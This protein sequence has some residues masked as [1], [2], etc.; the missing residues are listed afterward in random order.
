MGGNFSKTEDIIW[1]KKK[2]QPALRFRTV[3][4]AGPKA[5]KAELSRLRTVT[6]KGTKADV[7][8]FFGDLI[9]AY[10]ACE[11]SI[12]DVGKS[13]SARTEAELL[14]ATVEEILERI[15]RHEKEDQQWRAA[16]RIFDPS[17]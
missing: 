2:V 1:I 10:N 14:R 7:F 5:I 16:N 4:E 12:E 8:D 3:E 9:I 11:K 15:A 6:P 17:Q 13:E